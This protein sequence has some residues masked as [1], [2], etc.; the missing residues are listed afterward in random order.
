[1]SLGM[2]SSYWLAK[3]KDHWDR[4]D[5][6]LA[7]SK[8]H[9]LKSLTRSE[10]QEMGLLYRQAAADLSTLREDPSGKS[11]ARFLNLLL[12]R[13]HNTIY[14]GQKSSAKGFFD[15][16]LHEYP[17][18][19]RRN[20]NLV[21]IATLLFAAG[22]I[23]GMLLTLTRPGFM[24]LFLGA[25]MVDTIEHHKMWTDSVVAVKPLAASGIMTNNISVCFA[26]F[27]YGLT[28]GLGTI[29]MMVFNGVMMGV[30]GTA[31]WLHGM[32]LPLWSFVAPHGVL[33]LPAIFISGAAG[34][35]IG[36][37]ILFPGLLSRRDSVAK[38][39][40]EAIRL[41][42]GMV[43]VLIVAGTIEGFISP[44]G[45]AP[46]LK[47]ALA[48]AIAVVFFGYLFSGGKREQTA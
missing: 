48:G 23:A 46:T 24:Y 32:S 15:F 11:Y 14:S 21:T 43:P 2:I 22:G 27:A 13:A 31:C 47:F 20:L 7:Q 19:F 41:V 28:A 5:V 30:I 17:R 33:E 35:R 29:Y 6:L 34:L 45:L 1:M 3:R 9:G 36:Q 18:L 42:L 4:L 37:G 16:F 38:A 12:A 25:G 40:A 26:S 8:K 44:S 10:L 39:G